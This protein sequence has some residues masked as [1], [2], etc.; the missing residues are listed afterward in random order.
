MGFLLSHTAD[1]SLSSDSETARWSPIELSVL[2]PGGQ[3]L[4]V[5][6]KIG[7]DPVVTHVAYDEI[8]DVRPLFADKSSISFAENDYPITA[9]RMAEVVGYGTWTTGY[10]LQESTSPLEP[11]FGAPALAL[12]SGIPLFQQP[13]PRV[14][15]VGLGFEVGFGTR[16]NGGTVFNAGATEDI[17]I[18]WI[19]HHS[20]LPAGYRALLG[21]G[22]GAT[23]WYYVRID[24]GGNLSFETND[25]STGTGPG[26]NVPIGS[27]YVGMA[28]LDRGANHQRIATVNLDGTGAQL[29]AALAPPVGAVGDVSNNFYLG[30]AVGIDCVEN[31]TLS[32]FWIGTGLGVA[33][34]MSANLATALENLRVIVSGR[35]ATVSILPNGGWTRPTVTIIPYTAIELT[36][37]DLISTREGSLAVDPAVAR[38]TPIELKLST[39]AGYSLLVIARIGDASIIPMVVYC[40]ELPT[41]NALGTTTG[42]QNIFHDKSGIAITGSIGAGRD[43][44]MSVLPNVGWIRES[45]RLTAYLTLEA[46]P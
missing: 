29:S 43:I 11:A 36:G 7:D 31:M 44:T 23:P 28:V 42:Y 21:K 39:P 40:D 10:M 9:A 17:C 5:V 8:D 35:T 14:D 27:W 26:I 41:V 22:S 20:A 37:T 2:V 38:F 1:G 3:S 16:F 12:I 33:A 30:A 15:D 45:V 25:G 24:V 18:A 6:A 4:A 46:T 34:G 19:G 32:A 13:G